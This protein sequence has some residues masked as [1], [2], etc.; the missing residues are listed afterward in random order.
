MRAVALC[1]ALLVSCADNPPIVYYLGGAFDAAEHKSFDEACERWN[2]VAIRQSYWTDDP[3][4]ATVRV[5]WRLDENLPHPNRDADGVSGPGVL[6][7]QRGAHGE[8]LDRIVT[9][10]IGHKLLGSDHLAPGE[11]GVMSENANQKEVSE[12]DK[13][14][15][16]RKHA[17]K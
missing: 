15:C 12:A 9:H 3:D 14:L 7:L 13:A 5:F 17:C 4:E 10:E 8:G 2:H 11:R 16:R 6:Y 1:L